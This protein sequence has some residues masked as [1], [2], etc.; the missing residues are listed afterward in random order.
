MR[1]SQRFIGTKMVAALD[2]LPPPIRSKPLIEKKASIAGFEAT[3]VRSVS[4]V[5]PVRSS[6][7]PSGSCT[8]AMM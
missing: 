1:S 7:A 3:L 8:A 5:R 2:L 6:V 4:V